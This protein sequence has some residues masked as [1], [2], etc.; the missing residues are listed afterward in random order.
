[1]DSLINYQIELAKTQIK[2]LRIKARFYK[3]S[4]IPSPWATAIETDITKAKFSIISMKKEL[5]Q[6]T[7]Q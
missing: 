1:M 6:W 3:K 2:A 4:P 7:K 5:A